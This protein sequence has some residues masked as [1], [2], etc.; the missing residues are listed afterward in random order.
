MHHPLAHLTRQ[1][2]VIPDL[3]QEGYQLLLGDHLSVL[4]LREEDG[5]LVAAGA[6]E[7]AALL[8]RVLDA[9]GDDGEEDVPSRVGDLGVDALEVVHVD[10]HQREGLR[11]RPCAALAKDGI[12]R[13][14]QPVQRIDEGLAVRQARVGVVVVV[15]VDAGGQ[16]VPLR[17]VPRQV[18]DHPLRP[19]GQRVLVEFDGDGGAVLPAE[20][21]LVDELVARGPQHLALRSAQD[22]LDEDRVRLTGE[23]HP[24]QKP[25]CLEVQEHHPSRGVVDDQRVGDLH[26][27]VLQGVQQH[28][29]GHREVADLVLAGGREAQ[30]EVDLVDDAGEDA[31]HDVQPSQDDPGQ[32]VDHQDGEAD[33]AVEEPHVGV[34]HGPL[35]LGVDVAGHDEGQG[36]G[37]VRP[38]DGAPRLLNEGRVILT[39][40]DDEGPVLADARR[41]VGAGDVE[42]DGKELAG[43]PQGG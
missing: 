18:E 40:D 33:A 17:Q 34:V 32:E 38:Q 15:P 35:P 42:G 41:R 25:P 39:R 13:L 36:V 24:V 9:L 21:P 22:V 23:V 12:V 4:V 10:D 28:V 27:D 29:D 31:P 16:V 5:E 43:R 14:Q 19:Q 26:D 3:A 6:E 30:V 7:G 20:H 2:N 11:S 37:R 8:Q 1:G